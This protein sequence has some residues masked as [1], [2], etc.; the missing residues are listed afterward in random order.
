MRKRGWY[1]QGQF[2]TPTSP[3]NLHISVNYGTLEM[4]DA[5]L[6]DLAECVA[7]LKQR[8]PLDSEMIRA[9]VGR[10]LANPAPEAFQKLSEMAG[11]Q[12]DRLPDEMALINEVLDALPDAVANEVLINYFNDLYV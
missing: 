4:A 1:L 3:R 9:E 11:I 5:L 2:S 12:S 8:T 10:V 7:L 6:K